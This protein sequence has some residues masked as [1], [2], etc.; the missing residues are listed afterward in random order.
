MRITALVC[1]SYYSLL[2][3]AVSVKRLVQKAA[4]YGYGAVALADVNSMYGVVDFCKSAEQVNIRAIIGV[5]ILTEAQSV[6]F[7]AENRAGY[8]NLCRIREHTWAE[9]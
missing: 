3:G 5:E 1:R 2:R 9:Q 7:L 6:I 4:E 8:R